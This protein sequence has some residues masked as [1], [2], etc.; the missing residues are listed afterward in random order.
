MQTNPQPPL[1]DAY[2][3]ADR[4]LRVRLSRIGCALAMA[5][6][7]AG[8]SL[9]YFV[10]P[11]E[12]RVFFEIRL[13]CVGALAIIL[14]LLATPFSHRYIRVLGISWALLPALAIGWMVWL[15]GGASSPYYA[16]L[17]LVMIAV[18]LFMPW[19]FVEV[20]LTCA[21][22]IGIYLVACFAR[23]VGPHDIDIFFNNAYFLILTAVICVITSY[24]IARR[25]VEDFRLR[26][27][28][29]ARNLLLADSNNRLA[30]LDR[31][32]SDFFANISHELR[33]PLTLILAPVEHLLNSSDVLRDDQRA[34]L[35]VVRNQALRLLRLINDLLELVRLEEGAARLDRT[36][37]DLCLLA[38]AMVDAVRHLANLKRLTLTASSEVAELPVDADAGRLEKVFL[39]LLTNAIKFTNSGGVI[40]VRC[41]RDGPNAVVEI[42]DTGIGISA[43][44][45]PKLF[46]RFRQVD[47]S[48]TRQYR[49]V[50]IGLALARD[51]IKAHGGTLT[52]T[53]ELGRGSIFRAELPLAADEAAPGATAIAAPSQA[54]AAPDALGDMHRAADRAQWDGVIPECATGNGAH[55]APSGAGK[56]SV[57]VV[58]DEPDMRRFLVSL[59][60]PEYRVWQAADGVE[61]VEVARLRRPDLILLDL[62]LP[63]MDG[64]AVCETLKNDAELKGIKIVL[65]TARMDERSKISAL[66]SGADDFLTKPFSTT[67]VQ[68]RV[69]NLLK[70]ADL[71]NSLRDQNAALEL[72]L[73]RLKETEVQLVQSEK[74]SAL[75]KLAA[76]L[77][78]EVNN[79]LNF[80]LT[81]LQF[82]QQSS[83][84][85][86]A[87]QETLTDIK[88]GMTRIRHIV[89]DLRTFAY[90]SE[91]DLRERFL[92]TDA[93]TVALR[94]V[95]HELKDITIDSAGLAGHAVLGSKN[96]VS[97]VFMNMVVNSAYALRAAHRP[98]PTIKISAETT[99]AET[100]TADMDDERTV[101]KVWDNG[102]GIPPEAIKKAMDPFFTTKAVGEGT[103]LGLSICHTIIK[104]HGGSVQLRS[105]GGQWTEARFD[106]PS[107]NST[108][109]NNNKENREWTPPTTTAN[110]PSSML[111]TKSSR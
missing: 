95:S 12:L 17:N 78:H 52:A 16:G 54:P 74:M 51:L 11:T 83:E 75:G 64:L 53:S 30:Q 13:L 111:M 81:A 103:G 33:T 34:T 66:E 44:N 23:G 26:Y 58:D 25:R 93:L 90:A 38:P 87:M 24:F 27:E 10:Y 96:Q 31:L 59:V 50:G 94:L 21:L 108:L 104:N 60:A 101:V 28:L 20:A 40:S 86:A 97:H 19:T 110:M 18:S 22:T 72:A 55:A 47:A 65:L 48:S 98:D 100:S 57:L 35:D 63:R 105:Q 4:E 61:A 15:V 106:L 41:R 46:E 36:R 43:E 56:F 6:M 82:A 107:A 39:N 14:T 67:E 88:D 79:P 49:G 80:T 8:V 73:T 92:L 109:D 69:A 45:L 37:T 77:M 3:R 76:G 89:S 9:D 29:D 42:S 1:K 85:D 99:S 68:T 91:A 62:M 102:A 7:L 84:G 2:A 5:L 70:S 71:E 32:K